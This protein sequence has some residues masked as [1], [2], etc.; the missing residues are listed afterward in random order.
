ME[1]IKNAHTSPH[2]KWLLDISILAS[3]LDF[4]GYHTNM[5]PH[6]K[7]DNVA[8][9]CSFGFLDWALLLKFFYKSEPL[10][11]TFLHFTLKQ[12]VPTGH[13]LSGITITILI[14]RICRICQPYLSGIGTWWHVNTSK[15]KIQLAISSAHHFDLAG[16]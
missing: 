14:C 12:G 13:H 1:N 4:L 8:D 16:C 9:E 15:M 6:F 3:E 5:K 2:L 10:P 7:S 11:F